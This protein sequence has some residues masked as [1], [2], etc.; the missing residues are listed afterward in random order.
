MLYLK[1]AGD[2]VSELR[3]YREGDS[4]RYIHWKKSSILAE[5]DFIIKEY[6]NN[7]YKLYFWLLIH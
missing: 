5:D 6:D 3:K 4:P 2:E 7:I 1:S